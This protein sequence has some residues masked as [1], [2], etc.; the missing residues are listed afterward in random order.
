MCEIKFECVLYVVIDRRESL[1]A[2]MLKHVARENTLSTI[3]STKVT[4]VV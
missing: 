2:V 4:T 3:S 1:Q